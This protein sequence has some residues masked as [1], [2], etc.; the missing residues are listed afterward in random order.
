[1]TDAEVR[2]ETGFCSVVQNTQRPGHVGGVGH[3]VVV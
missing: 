3:V 1:M 2:S